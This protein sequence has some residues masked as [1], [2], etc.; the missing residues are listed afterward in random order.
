MFNEFSNLVNIRQ[1]CRNF[2]GKAVEKEKLDKILDLSR[3]APSACN[4]QPWKVYCV[5]TKSVADEV[6]EALQGDNHNRFLDDVN[7]F[8]AVSE[9]NAKLRS[10]VGSNFDNNHFVKYDIGE[11]V[12][13]ITLSA[14]ALG[15]DTCII[16]WIDEDKLKKAL[17]LPDTEKCNLV[18]A[19]GYSDI[20]VREKIRKP[21]ED[22][23]K[24][25]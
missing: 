1:A 3:F 9:I 10:D 12:A 20:P 2:N 15:L 17:K 19:V 21:F 18:I 25:L 5:T 6:R 16:G 13:Y 24:F 22:T 4:S 8:I 11:I 7:T 23:V 14:K